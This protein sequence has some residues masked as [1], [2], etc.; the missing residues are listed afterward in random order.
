MARWSEIFPLVFPLV[1]RRYVDGPATNVAVTAPAGA[2]FVRAGVVG[3]GGYRTAGG[4]GSNIWGG[5]GAYAFD[6]EACE[7]GDIFTVQAGN[8]FNDTTLGDSWVKRPGGSILVYADRGRPN[9]TG[10]LIA[11]ST[12]TVV[13][14]GS[15]GTSSGGGRSGSD[16]GDPFPMGL[17]GKGADRSYAAF[18]GGGGRGVDWPYNAGDGRACLEFYSINPGFD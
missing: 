7:P 2:K 4:A 18:W 13:R 6:A 10:G 17:G 3:A 9:G 1:G 8:S 12:G 16:D 14:A 5:G 11:N 15:A